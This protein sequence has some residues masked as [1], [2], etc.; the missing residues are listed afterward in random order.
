MQQRGRNRRAEVGMPFE[1]PACPRVLA[2]GNR[3]AAPGDVLIDGERTAGAVLLRLEEISEARAR[4][5]LNVEEMPMPGGAFELVAQI[6]EDA[7]VGVRLDA[8][9]PRPLL[10]LITQVVAAFDLPVRAASQKTDLGIELL[11]HLRK[12]P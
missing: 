4:P 9:N 5:G 7:E 12:C 6:A 3:H 11:A 8:S 1:Y 2:G 10:R